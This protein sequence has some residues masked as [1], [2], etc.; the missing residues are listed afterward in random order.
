MKAVSASAVLMHQSMDVT[1][2]RPSHLTPALKSPI[3]TVPSPTG[4]KKIT[5]AER[6]GLPYAMIFS[7]IKSFR[8]QVCFEN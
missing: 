8:T 2:R 5:Q 4:T 1:R 3:V 7:I 6:V